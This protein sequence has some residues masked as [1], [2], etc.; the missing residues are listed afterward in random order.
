MVLL[1][2]PLCLA[3]LTTAFVQG[4]NRS[5]GRLVGPCDEYNGPCATICE[6]IDEALLMR[7]VLDVA[8][9]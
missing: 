3:G 1:R 7:D 2:S 4:P 8:V 6:P 9:V 5:T